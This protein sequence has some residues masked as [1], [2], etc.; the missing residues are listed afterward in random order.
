[1][2]CEEQRADSIREVQG[3][4]S[5]PKVL[6]GLIFPQLSDSH[7][8]TMARETC[9][10]VHESQGAAEVPMSPVLVTPIKMDE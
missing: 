8:Y 10:L 7:P 4:A 3:S 2:Q 9:A 5:T 6:L 1:M